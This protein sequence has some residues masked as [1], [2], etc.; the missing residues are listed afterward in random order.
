MAMNDT[1]RLGMPL[2]QPSQAQKHVTVNEAL[3]RLDGMV[4]PVLESVAVSQP[5]QIID[6]QCWGVPADATGDWAGRG[7]QIAV[8][9]NG[10]WIFAPAKRGMRAFVADRGVQAVFDGSEWV[11]GALTLSESR[12]GMIAGM[13]E[14]RVSLSSGTSYTTDVIIP[15]GVMVIGVGA[16]V[17]SS[18][19]GSISTWQLGTNGALNRFGSGLG[20]SRGS[21]SRGLLSTPFSYYSPEPL[22]IT[23]EN[24]RFYSGKVLLAVH[25]LA[26]RVPD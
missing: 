20:K 5:G 3:M 8:G 24:G 22:I 10:G 21:V 4:N 14:G 7:G 18:L 16:R 25:Y 2:L 12:S 19:T 1:T 26:V 9:S 11:L 17:V 23:A 13:V 6:G 15:D